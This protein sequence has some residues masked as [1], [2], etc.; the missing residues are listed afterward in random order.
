MVPVVYC[1]VNKTGLLKLIKFLMGLIKLKAKVLLGSEEQMEIEDKHDF[2]SIAASKEWQWRNIAISTEEI[3]RIIEYDKTKSIVEM[4]NDEKILVKES[5][6]LLY[7]KWDLAKEAEDIDA[8]I[9]KTEEIE[10]RK[11]DNEEEDDD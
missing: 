9:R 4:N 8:I 7:E 2:G 5:F 3:Y 6:D 11:K 10:R 1:V